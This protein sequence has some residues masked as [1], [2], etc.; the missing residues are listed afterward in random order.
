MSSAVSED[1]ALGVGQQGPEASFMDLSSKQQTYSSRFEWK[2]L[3][4]Y[5]E[6]QR[7]AR[8]TGKLDLEETGTETKTQSTAGGV[9]EGHHGWRGRPCPRWPVDTVA[10]TADTWILQV[11]VAVIL[12]QPGRIPCF[13]VSLTPNSDSRAVILIG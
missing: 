11:D 5:C 9:R 8:R 1:G 2:T 3:K 10:T 12:S 7:M 4:R 6:A 13:F